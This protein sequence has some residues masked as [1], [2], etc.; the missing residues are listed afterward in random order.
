[1]LTVVLAH[2]VFLWLPGPLWLKFLAGFFVPTVIGLLALKTKLA[3]C[4]TG[5]R[6]LVPVARVPD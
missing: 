1:M 6:Q 2:P 3:P 5:H 4:M